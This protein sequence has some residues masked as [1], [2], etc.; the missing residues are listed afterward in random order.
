MLE[1]TA[2]GYASGVIIVGLPMWVRIEDRLSLF[3]GDGGIV[4]PVKTVFYLRADPGFNIAKR[5]LI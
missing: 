5:D 2:R 3:E 4:V 1:G